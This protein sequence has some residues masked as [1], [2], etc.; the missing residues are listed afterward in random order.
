MVYRVFVAN[1][2][3]LHRGGIAVFYCKAEHFALEA[4]LLYGPNIVIFYL[5]LGR[6]R[7]NFVGYYIFLDYASTIE[8]V[9]EAI[10]QRP[11]GAALLAADNFNADLTKTEG[12]ARDEE[13]ALSLSTAGL[14]DTGYHLL[15]RKKI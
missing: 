11:Q 1:A 4:I 10:I 9:V 13:I 3:S 5:K 7:S 8:S 14:E 12:N 6:R 15:P 2:P